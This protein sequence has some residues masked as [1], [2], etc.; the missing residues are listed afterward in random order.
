M[1]VIEKEYINYWLII[2]CEVFFNMSSA[3]IMQVVY[4]K[5]SMGSTKAA[6]LLILSSFNSHKM[7]TRTLCLHALTLTLIHTNMY[8]VQYHCFRIIYY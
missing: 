7:C 6:A 2:R 3:C 1:Y 8:N 4:I 5:P